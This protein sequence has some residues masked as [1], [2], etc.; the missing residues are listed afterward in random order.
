LDQ[1]TVLDVDDDVYTIVVASMMILLL[2][3]YNECSR[4]HCLMKVKTTRR[5]LAP[6]HQ[7]QEGFSSQY[8]QQQQQLGII[9]LS[10][11]GSFFAACLWGARGGGVSY[12]GI[13]H[14]VLLITRIVLLLLFRVFRLK[15][16]IYPV[17][18]RDMPPESFQDR[19]S[20]GVSFILPWDD[21]ATTHYYLY[22]CLRVS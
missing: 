19:G 8:K 2:E 6:V 5:G 16:Q 13:V 4:M 21:D 20:D 12:T 10:L 3:E 1:N 15:F 18:V 14:S 7:K 9:L 17:R 11:L 22:L